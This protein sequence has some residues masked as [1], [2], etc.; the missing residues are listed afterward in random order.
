VDATLGRSKTKRISKLSLGRKP[1]IQE[2]GP[3][4]SERKAIIDAERDITDVHQPW[5]KGSIVCVVGQHS[6]KANPDQK[7][8]V[9]GILGASVPYESPTP[10]C[11]MQDGSYRAF[12]K[13]EFAKGIERVRKEPFAT[14]CPVKR[15]QGWL[16]DKSAEP[17]IFKA[18]LAQCQQQFQETQQESGTNASTYKTMM[19]SQREQLVIEVLSESDDDRTGTQ[20][21]HVKSEV[22][23]K[24]ESS[25]MAEMQRKLEKM[26][27][28]M[29]ALEPR[30]PQRRPKAPK[31]KSMPSAATLQLQI[32]SSEDGLSDS[33]SC[34]FSKAAN[35]KLKGAASKRVEKK[36]NN[37]LR[38]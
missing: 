26:K 18:E 3:K 28:K 22:Q 32:G 36:R 10:T 9:F 23:V 11:V 20:H 33:Y 5:N 8:F 13:S 6:N 21:V 29:D 31:I 12:T 37:D 35:R 17:G 1:N 15:L 38:A 24:V 16:R 34:D 2:A 19:T 4:N 27:K 30:L 25:A 14:R 7:C